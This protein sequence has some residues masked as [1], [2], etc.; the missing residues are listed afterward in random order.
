MT[1]P[2]ETDCGR[3]EAWRLNLRA[4]RMWF[5]K[6]RGYFVSTLLSSACGAL[7]PYVTIWLSARII[8]ELAGGQ[9]AR[10][11]TF[12]A[13]LTVAGTA[14][15]A[16]CNGALRRW[17]EYERRRLSTARFQSLADKMLDLDFAETERQEVHD[18][19]YQIRQNDQWGG[20]G[21]FRTLE[22]FPYF[23]KAV[24]QVLGGIGFTLTLFL[25]VLPA[26]HPLAALNS[27]LAMVLVLAAMVGAVALSSA[28]DNKASLMLTQ[29][30]RRF[31]A[32]NRVFGFYGFLPKDNKRA[33]DL[34]MYRQQEN[35]AGLVMN[36]SE[37]AFRPGSALAKLSQGKVGV[38]MGLAQSVSA[39][40]TCAVYLFV[41]LK[42]W[43]GAF[44]VGEV[45]RYIGAATQLFGGISLLMKSLGLVRANGLFL[46][47][48]FA[49]LDLPNPMYQGSLTTEKRSD[50]QYQVEFRDVSFRYP[51]S[52]AWALRH[53]NVSFRVGSRLAVVGPNG[54]GKTTFIKLLCRLYDP[55]EGEILL[56]G[57][58]IRK[59]RYDDYI[60]LFS[61][62]FQDF[63]L[64]SLPLGENVAGAV[65]Y[66]R[67][68]AKRCLADAG[69]ELRP[70]KLPQ[71]LDTY[72]YKDMEEGVNLSGGEAQKAAIARALYKDAPFL[73]LDEP[74]ASLDPIAEAE[75]YE[76]FNAIAGDRTAVYISHRLSSCKFCDAIAVFD[77]GAIV[78]TG[79]HAAL[80]ADETGLYHTLWQ[81]QAQYYT[82]P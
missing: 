72:L 59:Y 56:N 23:C 79:T 21:L 54:S 3:R 18:L 42:A 12:W 67:E 51:G 76:K 53:V 29:Q 41:C 37:M 46:R 38:L 62:V 71:G 57:I 27:P 22:L 8:S 28:A 1:K 48:T 24:V 43:G 5:G 15:L 30:Y 10:R 50:R 17:T 4:W 82:K 39:V 75:I 49:F 20:Y 63:R 11:L 73:I 52:D 64:P 34:R 33:A 7:A 19:Y 74:T 69:F 35:I 47:K 25:A 68:K 66:D 55:T 61:V 58:D 16:L 9:D 44:D 81:A 6:S 60:A 78:Q 26:G 14:L 65:Q 32:S 36:G 2:S 80:V 45:T 77:H 40:L 70:D 13:V 31:T